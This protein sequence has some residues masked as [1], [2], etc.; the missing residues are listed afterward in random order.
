[1]YRLDKTDIFARWLDKLRDPIGKARILARLRSLSLGHFGDCAPVGGGI[2][3]MRVHAGPGYRVY[4]MRKGQ[5]VILLL[6][7]GDKSSQNRDIAQA[8]R[9]A[10][11]LTRDGG[12]R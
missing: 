2:S 11:G 6:C 10:E 12:E 4:F 1:M 9:L 7:A 3:E 5:I 8:H